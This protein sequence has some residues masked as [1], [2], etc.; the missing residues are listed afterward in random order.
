[1]VEITWKLMKKE[2]MFDP[3]S[4]HGPYFLGLNVTEGFNLL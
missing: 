3:D 4:L 2:Q 1:M